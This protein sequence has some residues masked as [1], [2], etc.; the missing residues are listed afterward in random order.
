MGEGEDVGWVGVGAGV[1]D[2]VG[3]EEVEFVGCEVVDWCLH[4]SS[5]LGVGTR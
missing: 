4:T 2:D 1:H 3:L 5:F